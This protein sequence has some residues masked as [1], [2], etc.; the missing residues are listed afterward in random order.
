[1]SQKVFS[2]QLIEQTMR[3]LCPDAAGKVQPFWLP[4]LAAQQQGHDFIFVSEDE[5]AVLRTA[6]PIVGDGRDATP[7]VLQGRR[8]FA[9]RVWAWEMQLARLLRRLA[10]RDIG[11]TAFGTMTHSEIDTWLK[12]RLAAWFAGE[13]AKSQQAACALAVLQPLAFITGGPGTGKT[14]TVA[15]LLALLCGNGDNLPRI[16]LAAPTGK[17]AAH[18]GQALQA[19]LQQLPASGEAA[20]AEKV[21]EYLAVLEGQTLHRLLQLN[22]DGQTPFGDGKFVP[23]DVIVVDEASMLDWPLLLHLLG[24]VAPNA[25]CVLLGDEAQLPPVGLGGVL[26][27]LPS[28]TCITPSQAAQLAQWLPEV[29]FPVADA[30]KPLAANVARLLYSHRFDAAGGVGALA[31][32]VAAGAGWDV[33]AAFSQFEDELFLLNNDLSSLAERFFALQAAY[34]QAVAAGDAAACFAAQQSAVVLAARR[35]EAEA[36]NRAYVRVLQQ[37]G[38]AV[39]VQGY[40]VGQVLMV[41]QNDYATRVFNGDIGIVLPDEQGQLAAFFADGAGFRAVALGR[42]PACETAF[43]LTVHKSQ[44]SEYGEVW[45]LPPYGEDEGTLFGRR[46][47]YTAITRA[48]RRFGF[49]GEVADVQQAAG[50]VHVRRT[51]LARLL[52]QIW[53]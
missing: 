47:L 31:R 14:T 15:K 26:P 2:V 51:D 50:Q 40:F 28:E 20:L 46:L 11:R 4:L 6:A 29:P 37:H 30:V 32:A 42:L 38:L 13:T 1:M 17:A 23:Y 39:Q 25:R 27:V 36:F 44:G 21:R 49:A 48:R 24:S 8:L 41:A 53:D 7:L 10:V 34:W 19:A 5:A 22:M 9:G 45:L 3:Q 12:R 33:A 43:A 35:V 16:A 52:Q 18:M